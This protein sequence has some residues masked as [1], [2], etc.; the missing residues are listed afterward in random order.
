MNALDFYNNVN[1]HPNLDWLGVK[2]A[3][4]FVRCIS[5]E[6]I[7]ALSADEV[8]AHSWEELESLFL[9]KRNPVIIVWIT[10][11]VG[12]Y[13]Q[14]RNFNKSKLAELEDRRRIVTQL[15]D[16]EFESETLNIK[17]RELF[18]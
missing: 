1:A 12:Y 15:V 2:G 17:Q 11:V 13:A 8:L 9:G 7:H 6:A 3:E 14:V 10:R 5:M 18:E 4:V 16:G